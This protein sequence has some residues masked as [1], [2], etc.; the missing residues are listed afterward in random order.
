MV[1]EK[2]DRYVQKNETTLTPYTRTNSKWIKDLNVTLQTIKLLEEKISS[3][4]SDISFR[5][6]FSDVS[7]QV[8]ET[9]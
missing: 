3:K 9:K 1:L 4:I 7:P 2:L 8:R 5:N 6:M